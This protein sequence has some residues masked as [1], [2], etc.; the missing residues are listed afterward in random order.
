MEN[1]TRKPKI[2]QITTYFHPSV[3][4]V[5]RQ[6]EEIAVHLAEAGY[7]VEVWTT[8]ATHDKQKRMQ[9]L[10]D[11]Y[12]GLSIYRSAYW[13]SLGHFFRFAPGIVWNLIYRDYDIVHVH[14]VHDAHLFWAIIV[15]RL[16]GKR[17]VLTGHNPY[18]VD[19]Q[20]RGR[21]LHLFV[22]IYE[23]C[24]RP[25]LGM[26]NSYIALLDSE[27]KEVSRRFAI[28]SNKIVVIP[29]GIQETY[30]ETLGS[31]DSFY[32]TWELDPQRWRM[33]VGT[34]S[35][36]NYVKG[37]QN[38][39]L[40]VRKLPEVLFIFAG[41]DDGYLNELRHMYAQSQNVLFTGEYLPTEEVKDFYQAI[42]IFLLPSVY[43]PFGMT[44][45]EAM[46]QGKMLLVTDNGGCVEFVT[47][48]VGE[49]VPASNQEAWMERISYYM[50]HRDLLV[51]KSSRARQLAQ[52]YSWSVVMEQLQAVYEQS[53]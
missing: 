28:P 11:N 38:L 7:R 30:Y 40:A 24:L 13:I 15:C 39:Q 51:E 41:G 20:K 29:N 12:R 23:Y 1:V 14:N 21:A 35:R 45:V 22:R 36:M 2:A 46:A 42:D 10:R 37:I 16:R 33:I 44:A 19:K 50:E 49:V 5:E 4:G 53:L 31:K 3:G 48:E 8:N 43:E 25:F 26:L 17:I 6:A 47:P 9:R 52:K 27:R 32:K 34:V 18:V